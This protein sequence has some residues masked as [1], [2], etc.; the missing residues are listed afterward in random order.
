MSTPGRPEVDALPR[1]SAGALRSGPIRLSSNE[2]PYDPLP[3]V[4]QAL[5]DAEAG[6]EQYPDFG[7]TRLRAA[8]AST[9]GV[10]ADQVAVGCGASAVIYDLARLCCRPGDDVVSAWRSFEAYPILAGVAGAG[11]RPVPLDDAGRADLGAVAAAVDERTRLVF[12]CN[13]NNPTGTAFSDDEL[14]GFLARVPS[15]VLVVLDEAYIE[16][17]DDTV[18]DGVR[19]FRDDWPA[20]VAVVRTFSKAYG[21]AALRIGYC[22]AA[23]ALADRLRAV[24][25]PFGVSGPA[26][27][28]ATAALGEHAE[29]LR[30]AREVAARRD[31]L[32]ERLRAAGHPVAVSRANFLWLPTGERTAEFADGC[33]DAGIIVRAYGT[34][35]VR[36]TVGRPDDC[37]AFV[38]HVSRTRVA[39]GAA[40]GTGRVR[41]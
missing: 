4:R 30:R 1:Y 29:V 36:V 38:E 28:A 18:A 37:A 40:A 35:G 22:V 6:A 2:S 9:L 39:T 5:V 16:Y 33:A 23:P 31:A 41:R 8:L 27:L 7:A 26:Q 12:L 19:M 24:Q 13:P 15:H 10:S 34:D 11:W 3:A 14:R 20:N 17:A 21:L 32:A 25:I